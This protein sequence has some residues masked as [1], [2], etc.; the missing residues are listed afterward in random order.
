M[1]AKAWFNSELRVRQNELRYER[2]H[3]VHA[4]PT[5]QASQEKESLGFSFSEASGKESRDE[6]TA[7]FLSEKLEHKNV[8]ILSGG[9]SQIRSS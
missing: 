9:K 8:S 6:K 4:F 1:R 2:V 7:L 3:L 5:D